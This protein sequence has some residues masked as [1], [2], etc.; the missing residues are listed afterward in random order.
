MTQ[1]REGVMQSSWQ[2]SPQRLQGISGLME[3]PPQDSPGPPTDAGLP[4]PPHACVSL[5]EGG[6]ELDLLTPP[7]CE[8]ITHDGRLIIF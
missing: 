7:I 2:K 3:Q 1:S 8:T 4:L 6:A 5:L